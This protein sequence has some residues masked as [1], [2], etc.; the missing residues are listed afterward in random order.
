MQDKPKHLPAQSNISYGW[1]L[2]GMVIVLLMTFTFAANG[3]NT[4]VIW[5]DELTSVGHMGVF[6]P[7]YSLSQILDSIADKS[8]QHMPLFFVL[9]AGWAQIAGWS[10][11]ALRL[12]SALAGVLLIAWA[13]RFGADFINR[14]TGLVSA[15]LLGSSAFMVIYLHEIRMYSLFM[16]LTAMHT[17]LYWRIAHRRRVTRMTWILFILTTSALFYTHIFSTV[18]FAGLG[19]YHLLFVDKSR[20]WLMVLF[21]WGVGT[22]LFLPY[23]PTVIKGFTLATNKVTTFTTALST[24]ELLET[25]AYL[26]TNGLPVI[27][28]PLVGLVL[29][30]L[31]RTR[32]QMILRF[33]FVSVVMF[34]VLVLINERFGLVPLRRARY[35]LILWFPFLL[36]FAYGLTCVPYWFIVTTGLIVIWGVSGWNLYRL[37]SFSDHIG[38]IDAINFYPPMHEYLVEFDG[39]TRSHDYI[40]GFTDANFV[41]KK[42]KH[43][44]STADYYMEAQLGIDG[45][46]VPSY[47][48]VEEL[49]TDIPDKLANHPYLLL[50]YNPLDKP[51]NFDIVLDII[52]QDYIAC[53][54]VIDKSGLFVQRYVHRSFACDHEYTP[55]VYANGVTIVDKDVQYDSATNIVQI[56]TGWVVADEQLLYE[57]NVSLQ[58]VTNDWQNAGQTDRHLHDDL[59]KWYVAELSTEGLSAGDYRVMVILYHRDTGEKVIGTDLITGETGNILP[60]LTFTIGL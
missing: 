14:R 26:L 28:I 5:F 43:N 24:P 21:G 18:L 2:L 22:V 45:T 11:L 20:R 16:M 8:P 37:P 33:L 13:Y 42:G 4:D 25:L 53:E 10:Q 38:T 41:N 54:V 32:N 30:A 6:D 29:Y 46:F 59:L 23:V 58:I 50:T 49:K 35:L 1:S 39:K 12:I 52:R 36:L 15:L 3:L 9:G 44:K 56:L 17:W 57:Y 51:D 31:W 55:I 40:V 60:L 48:D 19:I 34:V 27:L 7:P 47:F